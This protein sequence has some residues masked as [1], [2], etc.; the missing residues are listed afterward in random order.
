M[1]YINTHK[2]GLGATQSE[3]RHLNS[4]S[5]AKLS[6]LPRRVGADDCVCVCVRVGVARRH[7][8]TSACLHQCRPSSGAFSSE[9]LTL[10]L[11]LLL[12]LSLLIKWHNFITF[13]GCSGISH[14]ST[15]NSNWSNRHRQTFQWP[16]HSRLPSLSTLVWLC[17][18]IGCHW[19]CHKWNGIHSRWLCDDEYDWKFK[20][21]NTHACK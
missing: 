6:C 1:V 8:H 17:L 10:L 11:W 18:E 15:T 21:I 7:K 19:N 20:F 4:H 16:R 5:F 14:T 12:L 2:L 3:W 13:C 9:S